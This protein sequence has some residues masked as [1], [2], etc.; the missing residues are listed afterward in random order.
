MLRRHIAKGGTKPDLGFSFSAVNDVFTRPNLVRGRAFRGYA[1]WIGLA[2]CGVTVVAPVIQR[3]LQEARRARQETPVE[4]KQSPAL[5][6][7][8]ERRVFEVLASQYVG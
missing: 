2:E 4:S 3:T 5:L 8:R 7:L 1:F 6:R